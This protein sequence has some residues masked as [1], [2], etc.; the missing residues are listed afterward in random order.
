MKSTSTIATS[1]GFSQALQA[2]I[3]DLS[4]LAECDLTV[5]LRTP[6]TGEF[7]AIKARLGI[8]VSNINEV[9]KQMAEIADSIS[10][11]SAEIAHA[12]EDLATRTQE[13]ADAIATTS[14]SMEQL[15]G[16]VR[17]NAESAERAN[18]LVREANALAD[19]GR[20]AAQ[21]MVE[22][23]L[24][25]R[26]STAR[27]EDFIRIINE[28]AFQTQILALNA[29]VEA[30]R[31]GEHGR[32]FAVVADEV[33]ALAQRCSSA[34]RDI[35]LLIE[36]S[37]K[38]VNQGQAVATETG[39]KMDQI[40]ASVRESS[41]LMDRIAAAAREQS[42]GIQGANGALT[43]IDGITRQNRELVEAL[44]ANTN[45]LQRQSSFMSDAVNVFRLDS[46]QLTHPT[47]RQMQQAAIDAAAAISKV[48]NDAVSRGEISLEDLFDDDYQ[49]ITGTNPQ[50][51]STR[52]DTLTDRLFPSVQERVLEQSTGAVYA[53][54]VDRNGYFPTHN[55]KFSKPL[56]GDYTS[57]LTGNRTKRIFDD[58]VGHTCGSHGEPFKLQAYR[59]DTGEL[60][61]DMSAP[62][63]VGG[64]HWGGF[65]IGYRIE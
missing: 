16:T 10:G 42:Q 14:A 51:F 5:A 40:V 59:R 20:A 22:A 25:I 28:V 62:I 36:E 45:A 18:A 46:R 64:Y 34:T 35:K 44:A 23:M 11:Q 65:R 47:H 6:A 1:D 19:E 15:S 2:L 55:R 48:L 13:Q 58:R 54:A 7:A 24:A 8:T 41:A 27:I 39:T 49:P 3:A 56:T 57:D 60:M 38:E 21:Q 37:T 12:N 52:F 30:A 63:E 43:Q 61:F 9:L 26:S 50:K 17:E 31:A 4:S 32:G 33:R 29:A 53:G